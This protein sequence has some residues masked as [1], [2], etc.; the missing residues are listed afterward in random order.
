MNEAKSIMEVLIEKSTVG[1]VGNRDTQVCSICN[2][3]LGMRNKNNESLIL[4]V[5]D[6]KFHMKCFYEEK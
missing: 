2:A 3:P 4:T 5:C 6:H 1:F